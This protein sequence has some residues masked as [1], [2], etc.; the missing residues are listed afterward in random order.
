[1]IDLI[2]GAELSPLGFERS[3]LRRWVAAVQPPIR[4]IVEFQALK[5][6]VYSARWGFY[7]D[8]VPLLHSDELRWKGTAKTA[9]FDLC[10]D[11]I[12]QAGV[13][14]DW[15]S[16]PRPIWPHDVGNFAKIDFAVKESMRAAKLDFGRAN[17]ISDIVAMFE[18]RATMRFQ[19]FALEH[20]TQTHLAWGL[21]LIAIGETA[22]GERHIKLFCV[23][24][25]IDRNDR[26]IRQAVL[27]AKEV[28]TASK[29][30]PD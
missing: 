20:Y 7:L 30:S 25:L 9:D 26:M 16:F 23:R 18:E 2:I 6:S 19:R 24:Y 22:E 29:R 1:M 27:A 15:C 5:G 28:R 11:P 13:Q 4:K 3:R 17:S 21:S 8:F 10:I 12:D 14:L